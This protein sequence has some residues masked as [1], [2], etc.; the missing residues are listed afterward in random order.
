M[1]FKK[2]LTIIGVLLIASLVFYI[3]NY[4]QKFDAQG[5]DLKEG[6]LLAAQYCS[7]CHQ[8]P[9]P[10][11]LPKAVWAQSVLPAMGL[12][13]GAVKSHKDFDSLGRE[14]FSTKA[15]IS[16]EKW[17]LLQDYYVALA[18]EKMPAQDRESAV[19]HDL[20][21]FS[22]QLPTKSD[23][24]GKFE[25]ASYVR[26]DPAKHRLIIA[27]GVSNQFYLLNQRLEVIQK[28]SL[29]GTLVNLDVNSKN[30]R[31]TLIGKNYLSNPLQDGS[32]CSFDIAASNQISFANTLFSK[33][34][35]PLKCLS[36]D[37]NNDGFQDEIIAEFG[38][39]KGKLTWRSLDK[40]NH[41]TEHVLKD[42]P[43]A[44]DF[45]IFDYNNDGLPDIWALFA[46]ADEG[47]F[48][49]TNKGNGR[50]ESSKIM[51][52]PPAY[53][54]SSFSLIDLNH[55]GFK[56]IL[57]TCGDNADLSQVL[58]PYH[59][60]YIFINNGHNQ[61]SQKYFYPLNGCYKAIANDFD[62]DGDLDIAAISAFPAATT[63]W[64]SFVYLEH[65]AN[66][67]YQAF[68]LPKGTT[69]QKGLTMDVG[70][71]DG[72]GRADILLGNKFYTSNKDAY[73]EPLF[74][75]LKNKFPIKRVQ[76]TK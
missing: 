53:G 33:L 46:Q 24:N 19:N 32:V 34:S 36:V 54:S 67:N 28:S 25:L 59:G 38:N 23:F 13:L 68:T 44:I 62:G 65:K 17:K 42:L 63:P 61:F 1:K 73:S 70:D 7:S 37:L 18:P 31:A 55:D 41:Y 50:F 20:P 21:G 76:I 39:L 29:P 27:D 22:I 12:F 51:G 60:I 57:Y 10:L 8:L 3:G 43:G 2:P 72:D 58:K 71:V 4:N 64:E 47:I 14:F 74:I 5:A 48:L 52:F 49:F 75:L 40:Y 26:I 69:F 30:P 45:D 66:F 15:L 6:K 9:S 35:R 16:D 56:D 11:L